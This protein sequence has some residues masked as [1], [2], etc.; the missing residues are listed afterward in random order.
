MLEQQF[1][2]KTKA[3]YKI[4]TPRKSTVGATGESILLLGTKVSPHLV[5]PS[6]FYFY[7]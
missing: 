7:P 6:E 3:K 4:F 1:F 2:P 5:V